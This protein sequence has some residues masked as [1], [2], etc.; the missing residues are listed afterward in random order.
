MVYDYFGI[1]LELVPDP[2][3][4]NLERASNDPPREI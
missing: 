3:G 2:W 4:S 1:F